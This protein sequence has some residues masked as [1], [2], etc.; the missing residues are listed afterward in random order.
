MSA[1]KSHKRPTTHEV[2]THEVDEE[3]SAGS[4]ST[5][6][7]ERANER[8]SSRPIKDV[9]VT[10]RMTAKDAGNL[11]L[12][13][14]ELGAAS[15]PDAIR[16]II[17]MVSALQSS[18]TYQSGKAQIPVGAVNEALL[19]DVRDA[20]RQVTKSYNERTREI[21]FIGHNWNQIAKVANATGKVDADALHGIDRT[22]AEIRRQMAADAERDAK[23]LAVLPFQ[24]L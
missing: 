15:G 20:V 6:A 14:A 7:S 19:A 10:V 22:L 2:D 24:S 12:L 16:E 8:S 4:R 11:A 9:V 21:H 3:S 5:A 13:Q 23:V 1:A 18:T 17:R